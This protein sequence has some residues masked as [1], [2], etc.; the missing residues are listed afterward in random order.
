MCPWN[1]ERDTNVFVR[2]RNVWRSGIADHTE[3]L[4]LDGFGWYR[5]YGNSVC[6]L[7]HR[8]Q[9]AISGSEFSTFDMCSELGFNLE[10]QSEVCSRT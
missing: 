9:S 6:S 4:G 5:R 2:I 8:M 1:N 3:L 10:Q 7:S